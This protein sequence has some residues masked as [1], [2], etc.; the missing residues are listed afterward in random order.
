MLMVEYRDKMSLPRKEDGGPT[1]S[2]ISR[3]ATYFRFYTG[4]RRYSW[5]R[6]S[7]RSRIPDDYGKGHRSRLHGRIVNSS[8][9]PPESIYR[10]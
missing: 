1:L 8:R 6:R 9:G 7:E 5:Y 10:V 2:G 3:E 4:L